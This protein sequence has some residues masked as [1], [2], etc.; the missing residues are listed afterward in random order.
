M[1]TSRRFL[2][3][4][5]SRE[6]A[7]GDGLDNGERVL[8]TMTELT[9]EQ[10]HLFVHLGQLHLADRLRGNDKEQQAGHKQ[11]RRQRQSARHV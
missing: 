1:K 10:R 5:A 4:L 6:A 11:A 8:D 2:N 9:D 3:R 7:R